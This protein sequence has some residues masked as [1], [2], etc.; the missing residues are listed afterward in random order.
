MK[1]YMDYGAAKP[2]DPAV[3][4][5]M[6]PYYSETYGNPAAFY[7]IGFEAYNA[8]N[9]AREQVANLI[10]AGKGE[11][12]FTSCATE[13][14]NLAILGI[15]QRYKKRGK[16]VIISEIEHISVINI[17]KELTRQGFEVLHAPVDSDG[18]LD[19]EKYKELVNNDTVI[20]T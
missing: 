15:A 11:I 2:V 13:A 12:I 9:K 4:D 3:L 14:N 1:V 10:G 17:S 20:V 8:V 18:I 7:N 16:R 19:L 6:M 5:A